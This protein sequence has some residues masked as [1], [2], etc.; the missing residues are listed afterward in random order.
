MSLYVVQA[1]DASDA[2]LVRA[3]F[4]RDGFSWPAFVFAQLWLLYK[5][6]W[7]PLLIWIVLEIAFILLIVPQLSGGT[8]VGVDLLAHLYIG[9]E[10]S[11]LLQRRGEHGAALIDLVEARD[12][13][14]AESIFFRRH[15]GRSTTEGATA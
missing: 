15:G 4:I 6:L 1:A 9:L 3:R 8:A 2:G 10:G 11:R 7:I 5:G 13:D 12:R 14:E